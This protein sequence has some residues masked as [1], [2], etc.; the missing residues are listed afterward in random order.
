MLQSGLM[1]NQ[2]LLPPFPTAAQPWNVNSAIPLSANA[3]SPLN[4]GPRR[5]SVDTQ[6][7]VEASP[8]PL[9]GT[10]VVPTTTIDSHTSGASEVSSD[11]SVVS[12][13]SDNEE[14]D[15][16][17]VHEA[18]SKPALSR[19]ERK[20]PEWPTSL[21]K[22]V[23]LPTMLTIMRVFGPEGLE[24]WR[25]DIHKLDKA[26]LERTFKQWNPHF[27]TWF[28]RRRG[29]WVPVLGFKEESIRRETARSALERK[30]SR[31]LR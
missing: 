29:Q 8:L 25:K 9:T 26:S 3:I 18:R 17:E 21:S 22:M 6:G 4:L 11:E 13:L 28:H 15:T 1:R 24:L 14:D 2:N 19:S 5:F 12:D 10:V 27:F 23:P 16:D 31:K 30:Q 7:L 20:E